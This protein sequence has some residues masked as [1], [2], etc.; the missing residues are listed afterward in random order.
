[1]LTTVSDT[2]GPGIELTTYST[3]SDV[4]NKFSNRP[5]VVLGDIFK[6]P[7]RTGRGVLSCIICLIIARPDPYDVCRLGNSTAKAHFTIFFTA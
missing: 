4:L 1:M 2:T 6:R 3:G 7:Y 5:V